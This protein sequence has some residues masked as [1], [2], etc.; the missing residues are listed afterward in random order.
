MM[1][2]VLFSALAALA[3]A[4]MGSAYAAD[5]QDP[6]VQV[7]RG[8]DYKLGV[9]EFNDYAATYG[10]TSG[11]H[12]KFVRSGNQRFY[13]ELSDTPREQMY[14]MSKGVFVT[15]GGAR[16]EFSEDGNE[17]TINNFERMSPKVAMQ[18]LENVTVVASR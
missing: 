7:R 2:K 16:V 6:T 11:Q 10:L 17:V 1:K 4:S 8:S 3:L 14:A 5:P 13:A 9:A 18:Q 12:V 15:A